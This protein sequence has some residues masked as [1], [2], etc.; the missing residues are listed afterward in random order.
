ML[1]IITLQVAFDMTC[2]VRGKLEGNLYIP[3]LK[4]TSDPQF[5]QKELLQKL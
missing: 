1:A 2:L 4:L 3:V 5:P